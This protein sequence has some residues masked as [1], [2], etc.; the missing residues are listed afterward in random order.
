MRSDIEAAARRF[1]RVERESIIA[2]VEQALAHGGLEAHIADLVLAFAVGAGDVEATRAFDDLVSKDIV[3]AIR[4]V[5]AAP[6]F[7]DE[8]TQRTRV[9]LVV[10][11]KRLLAYRGTGPLRAWVAITAQRLALN[12]KREERPASDD[13]PLSDLVDS[14]ADPETKHLKTLYRGEFRAAL[15]TALAALSDRERAI[16]R[17]RFVEG[18]ELAHIGKLYRVHESTVSR[19]ISA[20]LEDVERASRKALM[21]RLAVTATTADSVAR[22]VQSGLDLSIARLLR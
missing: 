10:G 4:R 17:L 22:M 12:A 19:W 2:H 11:E 15:S 16:L 7:V 8:I 13:D 3:Q 21:A 6:A 5:D 14:D 1:P 20:A 18:L 9:R